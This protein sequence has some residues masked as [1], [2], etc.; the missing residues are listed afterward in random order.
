[1]IQFE[2]SNQTEDKAGI[3]LKASNQTEDKA[4]I[5]LKTSNQTEDSGAFNY[6][7]PAA[8]KFNDVHILSK[9][10]VHIFRDVTKLDCMRVYVS[11]KLSAG[12]WCSK[13]FRKA[14]ATAARCRRCDNRWYLMPSHTHLTIGQIIIR[15][16]LGCGDAARS[17]NEAVP[18][19]QFDFITT[20]DDTM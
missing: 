3:Q 17:G 19:S 4:A 6:W 5:Q 12:K 20:I 16:S 7:Y 13:S 8:N 2:A 11:G 1:M 14:M 9:L 10:T 15:A 18:L